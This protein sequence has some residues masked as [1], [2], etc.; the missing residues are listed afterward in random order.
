MGKRGHIWIGLT[1][2]A[3]LETEPAAHLVL[4]QN[5]RPVQKVWQRHAPALSSIKKHLKAGDQVGIIPASIAAFVI[6][7][8]YDLANAVQEAIRY[9][10]A[11]VGHHPTLTPGHGHLYYRA[12]DPS[13]P[14][15]SLHAFGEYRSRHGYVVI[16]D[17]PA[18]LGM[19]AD[20]HTATPVSAQTFLSNC[21]APPLAVRQM[22]AAKPGRRN[23]TANKAIFEAARNGEAVEPIITAAIES[24]LPRDEVRATAASAIGAAKHKPKLPVNAAGFETA[25]KM[26]D[27]D[28]RLN[29]RSQQVEYSKAKKTLA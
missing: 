28:L 9:L 14:A 29:I 1:V 26:L 13:P 12:G 25:I 6:D 8:D 3:L 24:G 21:P 11:L 17:W 16:Y 20:L 18:F 27:V 5:K 19:L 22:R 10:G 23:D 4:C 15:N 7:V 2:V